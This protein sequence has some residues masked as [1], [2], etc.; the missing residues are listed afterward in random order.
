[1]E[2]EKEL[3]LQKVRKDQKRKE[4]RFVSAAKAISSL[5]LPGPA[6]KRPRPITPIITEQADIEEPA[7]AQTPAQE[8][9]NTNRYCGKIL[10]S[11]DANFTLFCRRRHRPVRAA[12]GQLRMNAESVLTLYICE[13]LR[14]ISA[15]LTNHRWNRASPTAGE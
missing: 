6:P 3:H 11:C 5:P 4:S 10:W 12:A 1:M 14:K 9:S 8:N 15:G 13:C 7:A 2:E